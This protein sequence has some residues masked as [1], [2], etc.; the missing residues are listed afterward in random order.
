[1]VARYFWRHS[2]A[3]T[4]IARAQPFLISETGAGA[5][6][7]WRDNRTTQIVA[8]GY[9]GGRG[10]LAAGS[11]LAKRNAT[12]QQAVAW[13][14]GEAACRGFTFRSDQM[15]PRSAVPMYFK[16]L[17]NMNGD[18]DWVSWSKGHPLPPKWS[19]P[20]QA[21]LVGGTYLTFLTLLN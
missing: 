1:M 14:N 7:E 17:A 9:A 15:E 3:R 2:S 18:A 5:I 13:C 19:Q 11:D 12:W 20:F 16:S 4:R 21:D 8:G 6:Y 10:A